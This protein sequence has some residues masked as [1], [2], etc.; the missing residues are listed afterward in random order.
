MLIHG[1]GRL[2]PNQQMHLSQPT[3]YVS[4][5]IDLASFSFITLDRVY[6]V[7]FLEALTSCTVALPSPGFKLTV[8][9]CSSSKHLRRNSSL[10]ETNG[11]RTGTAQVVRLQSFWSVIFNIDWASSDEPN[12]VLQ[13]KRLITRFYFHYAMLVLN[14]FGL[15]NALER[16]NI[17]IGHFFGRCHSSAMAC[18][19]L[20][21]DELGPSGFLKYS[22]DS[23]FVFTSYA[24]LSLLKVR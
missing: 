14:S 5:P 4:S 2:P 22:P 7:F 17:D 10:G 3:L 13:Y 24:V 11:L 6:N 12:P 16:S 21:R 23:H 18:A 1:S 19:L 20:I 15:Q 8:T 9:T